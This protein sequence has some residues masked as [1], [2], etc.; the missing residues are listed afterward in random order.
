MWK[1]KIM[2]V[3]VTKSLL[4]YL[5][6]LKPLPQDPADSHHI[7]WLPT[8]TEEIEAVEKYEEDFATWLEKDT[9]VKYL[10]MSTIPDSIY[11]SLMGKNT[12]HDFFLALKEWFE[13]CSFV[14]SV[15]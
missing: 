9:I 2:T 4:G 14:V 8:T 15:E 6:G 11:I 13:N 7:V 3:L 1:N 10:I 5:H 12:S